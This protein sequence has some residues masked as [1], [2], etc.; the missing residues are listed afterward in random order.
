MSFR[1][2]G[3]VNRSSKNHIVTNEYAVSSTLITKQVS[4]TTEEE[5]SLTVVTHNCDIA[6]N[7]SLDVSNG[8]TGRNGLQIYN[9]SVSNEL[10]LDLSSNMKLN[11]SLVASGD[12]NCGDVDCSILKTTKMQTKSDYRLKTNVK[13]LDDKYTLDHIR[14]V[15]YDM[16]DATEIGVLAHEIQEIYPFLVTGQKDGDE[17]QSVNYIGLIGILIKEIQTL[18]KQI[19]NNK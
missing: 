1:K 13:T 7:G 15:I 10:V 18:K 8:I 12:I 2:I 9:N 6:G 19:L 5:G 4:S 16:N 17:M 11:G 14:P 3:G